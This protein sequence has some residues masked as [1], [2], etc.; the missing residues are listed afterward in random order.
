MLTDTDQCRLHTH[1]NLFKLISKI[2]R[3]LLTW[4]F[5]GFVI[6]ALQWIFCIR[7]PETQYSQTTNNARKARTFDHLSSLCHHKVARV[8]TGK[9]L[10]FKSKRVEM[11]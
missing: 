10:T 2:V 8:E 3:L 6:G 4:N 7:Y 1:F 11:T 9:I 5:T